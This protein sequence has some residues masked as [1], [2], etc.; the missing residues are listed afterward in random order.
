MSPHCRGQSRQIKLLKHEFAIASVLSHASIISMWEW[1]EVNGLAYIVMEHFAG[2]NLKQ[3]I[4][5]SRQARS[6]LIERILL[7]VGGALEHLHGQGIIHRDV[8]PDNVLVGEHGQVKLIDFA[9]ARKMRGWLGS[10]FQSS[11]KPQGTLS[12]M[13]PEQIR[14]QAQ[15]QCADIYS[16]GC[17]AYELVCGRPPFTGDT[18]HDLLQKHLH[19]PIPSLKTAEPQVAD[20]FDELVQATLAK[21]P[22]DRP[23]SM[24]ALLAHIRKCHV[25]K[26]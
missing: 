26:D 2:P 10:W 5:E 8:K 23:Q 1:G 11:P 4:H 24:S 21:Q 25:F 6:G 13:S 3:W 12:Y 17:V 9:L 14:N 19:S 15:D 22:Q 20:T 7:H 16:F 18:P